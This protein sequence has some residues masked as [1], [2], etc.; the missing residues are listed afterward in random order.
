MQIVHQFLL[1]M[2][3]LERE[4]GE[5]GRPRGESGAGHARHAKKFAACAHEADPVQ[6]MIRPGG[7]GPAGE[8]P[9]AA[10]R[11]AVDPTSHALLP[12]D[13]TT[14]VTPGVAGGLATVPTAVAR[15][16]EL[17]VVVARAQHIARD[18]DRAHTIPGAPEIKIFAGAAAAPSL[19]HLAVKVAGQ[20]ATVAAKTG[21][22]GRIE[23]Q[24]PLGPA[25]QTLVGAHEVEVPECL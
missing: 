2:G 24:S 5:L 15:R 11:V 20:Q 17:L 21:A 23:P 18:P 16:A 6:N 4:D 22:I 12:A 19:H 9:R 8:F 7:I 13:T 25:N 10:Y 3:L 1:D 14:S